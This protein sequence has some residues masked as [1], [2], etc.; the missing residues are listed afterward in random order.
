MS[1]AD[2]TPRRA[3]ATI[4]RRWERKE[5][6]IDLLRDE[7]LKKQQSWDE[8][9]RALLTEMT[10]GVVRNLRA[11][12]QELDG[13]LTSG[14]RNVEESLLAIL[15]VGLYQI[16]FLDRVP[17]HAAVDEAVEHAKELR[18]KGG[19]GLVNAVL[20]RAV[21][22]G[23]KAKSST[24][25][26]E[27][28]YTEWRVKWSAQWT[29]EKADELIRF[30]AVH[31]PVGLRRNLLK[32]A[33]DEEWLNLLRS[34]GVDPQH[35]SICPGFAYARNVRPPTLPSFQDGRTTVQDP[36]ASIPVMLLDPQ[37]GERVLD[38]CGAPGGKTALIW[39]RMGG[40]GT[41]VSVDRDER[42]SERIR[43]GLK[44]LGHGAVKVVTAD[45]L[46][47]EIPPGDRVLIDVPCSGTG[48][49]HRRA[50]LTARRSPADLVQMTLLQ[51]NLLERAA[52]FVKPGG[53]LVYSTCSLE[54]EENQRRAA[55]FDRTFEGRFIRGEVTDGIQPDWIVGAG[56]VM[57]WPPRDGIDGS[58]SIRWTKVE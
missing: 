43:E 49:A 9:D 23:S 27:E 46:D 25:S 57:T 20:R 17:A 40:Q 36:G 8:R 12:D 21:R 30:Y 11:L 3:A 29:G 58:Y 22:E 34:E 42:R 26:A 13:Y 56:E 39:E 47:L 38:L 14:V 24:L 44:R 6:T 35:L 33:S 18:G 51:S 37:P 10:Y 41:L 52:E 7:F 16:R 19:A 48:V 54:P 15:R 2:T 4:L 45:V 50:D 55:E 1:G 32:T 28:S 5:G 53:V 31:P